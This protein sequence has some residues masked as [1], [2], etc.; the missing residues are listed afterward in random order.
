MAD[1]A[2]EGPLAPTV[3]GLV[4]AAELSFVLPH[5]H[6]LFDFTSRWIAPK[7]ADAER[8]AANEPITLPRLGLLR[9]HARCSITALRAPPAD[10]LLAELVALREAFAGRGVTV[11]DCTP[12]DCGRD[13]AGLRAL[14][15]S[16]G[17]RIV[18]ASSAAAADVTHALRRAAEELAREADEPLTDAAVVAAAATLVADRLVAEL[19]EG[20]TISGVSEPVRAGVLTLGESLKEVLSPTANP[21]TTTEVARTRDT[22]L[23]G[24]A[25]AQMRTGAPLVCPIPAC[26][27]EDEPSGTAP[28]GDGGATSVASLVGALIEHG[29]SPAALVVA[30]AQNLLLAPLKPMHMDGPAHAAAGRAALL[31]VL[32]LGAVLCFDGVGDSWAVAGATAVPAERCPPLTD[33]H[34]AKEV[35]YF[36]VRGFRSQLLLSHAVA[37]CLQLEVYGGGGLRHLSRSF[38]PSLALVGLSAEDVAACTGA[39]AARLLSWWTPVPPPPRVVKEWECAGCHRR[40][41]EA[42]NPAEALPDDQ[43]YY[44]KFEHRYCSTSCLAAHR[45][46]GY[47]LPFSCAPPPP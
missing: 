44:E 13:P 23:R 12:A 43:Q 1:A 8:P 9:R 24:V 41:D 46:V 42:V 5:E 17:V 36:A 16:S 20:L 26:I 6:L 34:L 21:A 19:S 25:Q 7:A 39:N 18:M 47:K 15:E 31:S 38:V 32:E 11:V 37:S 33:A 40:F 35:G 14:S 27:S 3:T 4:S 22:L 10:V 30:H 45:K 2:S 29:A 28:G